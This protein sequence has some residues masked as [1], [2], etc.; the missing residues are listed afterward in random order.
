MNMAFIPIKS[1]LSSISLL[2]TSSTGSAYNTIIT[3]NFGIFPVEMLSYVSE[4]YIY[5]E[6]RV[7]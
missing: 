1:Y 4:I 6:N 5:L 3:P 7:F 2:E